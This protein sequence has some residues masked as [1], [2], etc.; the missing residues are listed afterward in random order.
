MNEIAR[1]GAEVRRRREAMGLSQVTF[2]EHAGLSPSCIVSVENAYHP[3]AVSTVLSIAKGLCVAPGDLF[4]LAD[5]S[6]KGVEFARLFQ[7]APR[8]VRAATLAVL[9]AAKRGAAS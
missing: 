2:A 7:R 1:F 9:R 4:G 5:L 8:E 3:P 6:P